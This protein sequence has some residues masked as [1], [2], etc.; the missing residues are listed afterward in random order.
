MFNTFFR[1]GVNACYSCR[2][3]IRGMTKAIGKFRLCAPCFE[4]PRTNARVRE[5]TKPYNPEEGVIERR[6]K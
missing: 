3:E 4:N 5:Y 6:K 1:P 2:K